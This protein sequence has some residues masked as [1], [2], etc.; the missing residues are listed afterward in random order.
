MDTR[1]LVN[2]EAVNGDETLK[3]RLRRG[4]GNSKKRPNTG[5]EGYAG[6]REFWRY[7]KGGDRAGEKEPGATGKSQTKP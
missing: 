4:D 1:D 2:R 6:G 3:G 5:H 7:S